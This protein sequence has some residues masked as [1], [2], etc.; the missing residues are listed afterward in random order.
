[1]SGPGPIQHLKEESFLH[2]VGRGRN[3]SSK[4]CDTLL[5]WLRDLPSGEILI[6]LSELHLVHWIVVE[7]SPCFYL[8]LQDTSTA[9]RLSA[10]LL[11]V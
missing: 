10:K 8:P 4:T 1:M 5:H 2:S 3:S 9:Y 6:L 7:D 11:G